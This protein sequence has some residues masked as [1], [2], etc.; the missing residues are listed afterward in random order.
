MSCF[1]ARTKHSER[2]Q[3]GRNNL[4]HDFELLP[5]HALLALNLRRADHVSILCGSLEGL[6]EAFANLDALKRAAAHQASAPLPQNE[7]TADPELS[8]ASL[9]ARDRPLIR[10]PEMA[11]RILTAAGSRA[12][13]ILLPE[14]KS[15]ATTPATG[16]EAHLE[17]LH[18]AA[19]T[20]SSR[21]VLITYVESA[22]LFYKTLPDVFP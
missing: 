19:A 9:P 12:P 22:L 5:D 21:E 3:S 4:A 7:E 1:R 20:G 10:T 17:P 16:Q 18:R 8:S 13:R 14:S 15:S 2:R 11:N 6:P